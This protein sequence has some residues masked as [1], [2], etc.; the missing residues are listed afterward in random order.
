MV[1]KFQNVCQARMGRNM[2]KSGSPN[3][4]STWLIFLCPR[5]SYFLYSFM[6]WCL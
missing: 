6:V 1:H 3:A 4:P 5:T 2:M